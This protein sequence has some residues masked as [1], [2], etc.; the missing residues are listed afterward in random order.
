VT[1]LRALFKR[2]NPESMPKKN[3]PPKG[4]AFAKASIA[5]SLSAGGD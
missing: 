1:R 2:D 5:T 4:A 3:R